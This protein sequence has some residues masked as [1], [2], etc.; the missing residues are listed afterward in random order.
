[1]LEFQYYL[2][3]YLSGTFSCSEFMNVYYCSSPV[4]LGVAYLDCVTAYSSFCS[5]I[6]TQT[7]PAVHTAQN[8]FYEDAGKAGFQACSVNSQGSVPITTTV[9]I[10]CIVDQGYCKYKTQMKKLLLQILAFI[11]E[12]CKCLK[13]SQTHKIMHNMIQP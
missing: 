4:T 1:M 2:V 13:F 9:I 6:Y 11:L 10:M 5:S 7:K 3:R 8:A 12:K